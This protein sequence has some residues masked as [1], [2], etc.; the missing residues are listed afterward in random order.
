[1]T[2]QRRRAR[3]FRAGRRRGVVWQD[4]FFDLSLGSAAQT[5]VDLTGAWDPEMRKGATV[6]R[7]IIHMVFRQLTINTES[8]MSYGI[9]MCE[10]DA[11]AAGAFSDPDQGDEQLGWLYRGFRLLLTPESDQII[12]NGILDVDIKA[13]R[14][15]PGED[16]LLTMVIAQ[17]A[18]GITT[19]VDGLVRVLIMRP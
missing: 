16:Q 15:F 11:F 7:T 19:R 8:K 1:M 9:Y 6:V 14:T 12:N 13:K 18:S 10:L 3:P 4:T 17:D 5:G 2:T